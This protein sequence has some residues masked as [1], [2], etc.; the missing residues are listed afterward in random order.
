M[1]WNRVAAI[2]QF[3]VWK[4]LVRL[5]GVS[6]PQNLWAA[7]APIRRSDR[8]SAGGGRC[9]ARLS[10]ARAPRGAAILFLVAGNEVGRL[11]P[12]SGH[13]Y[14]EQ[15]AVRGVIPTGCLSLLNR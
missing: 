9:D 10:A 8:P 6:P 2:P 11:L 5:G 14:R 13:S 7:G 3:S 15:G 4:L 12:A 1:A